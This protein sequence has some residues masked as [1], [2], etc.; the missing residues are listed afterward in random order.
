M[1]EKNTETQIQWMEL[2]VSRSSYRA[3]DRG[4]LMRW[5]IADIW[6]ELSKNTKETERSGL[7]EGTLTKKSLSLPS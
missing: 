7:S 1:E 4:G 6:G 5:Q 3:T 2:L